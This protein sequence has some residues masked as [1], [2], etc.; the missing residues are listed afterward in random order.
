[1]TESQSSGVCLNC[2]APLEGPFC[3]QCGQRAVPA[4]PTLREYAGDAW[5]EM[6][7]LDGRFARTL[8]TLITKP[9]RLTV[10]TLE[11]RRAH[12]IKPL[13][14]YLSASV[15][16]FL[17]AAAAP[18]VATNVHAVIPDREGAGRDI[19]IDM[20]DP[21]GAGAL[22]PEQRAQAL[23]N[24][25]KAPPLL[26]PMF[27]AAI[28]DPA[29]L[30]NGM[31]TAVPKAFFVMV[32]V[33]AVI[34][35]MF[36]RRRRFLQHLT[37]ALHMHAVL[38]LGLAV[39]EIVQF[40]WHLRAVQITGIVTMAFLAWYYVRALRTVYGSRIFATVAKSLGIAVCYFVV[41]VPVMAFLV[42]WSAMMR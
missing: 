32:P 16:Y 20:T 36:Y 37:F 40:T 1:M 30:R 28:L 33:F 17:I 38:F 8:S 4:Y 3:A 13:R 34:V 39:T 11:G 15:L 22:S 26:K 29:G 18:N 31:M 23:E 19:A 35:G 27:E 9:G 12:Y 2:G 21:R 24:I 5:E 6:S 10:D 41:W 7:G 25:E 42:L 14:L